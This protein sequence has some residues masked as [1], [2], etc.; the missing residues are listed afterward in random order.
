[1]PSSRRYLPW[2]ALWTGALAL[3]TAACNDL[4]GID[5]PH[6]TT[7]SGA[8]AAAAGSGG[9]AASG[10]AGSA[11]SGAMAG[12]GA[13]AGS[14]GA[15][16]GASGM[17]GAPATSS[18]GGAGGC[19][20]CDS[21]MHIALACGGEDCDDTNS[22]VYPGE[23]DYFTDPLP[24]GG[25][26]YDCAG[27]STPDPARNI[28]IKCSDY[29]LSQVNCENASPGYL[30]KM[31]PACGQPGTWGKCK[32]VGGLTYC[33]NQAIDAALKMGCK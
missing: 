1:M 30:D 28:G 20:D 29:N 19:C 25:F 17:G 8:A 5:P 21:D 11:G 18:T 2:A 31:I 32:W 15:M 24:G 9:A 10:G 14:A 27:G 12:S 13:A 3:A 23:P 7:G 26:N 22:L 6:T 33:Q 16:A 4:A